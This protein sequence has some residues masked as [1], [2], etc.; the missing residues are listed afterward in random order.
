M[1]QANFRSWFSKCFLPAVA[2]TLAKGPVIL[3]LDGHHSHLGIE[4]IQMAKQ[5]KV[6]P[7]CIPSHTSHILQPLDVGVY[8]PL[9]KSWKEITKAY[10][11]STRASVISKQV[12]PSLL[13]E[14]WTKSFKSC[15]LTSGFRVCGLYSY[16]LPSFRHTKLPSHYHLQIQR[17]IPSAHFQWL[18][19]PSAQNCG[20]I[21]C[22]IYTQRTQHQ[23]RRLGSVP[24]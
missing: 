19:H 3:F 18:K 24:G 1:E 20:T 8:G 17:I 12:F 11:S 21:L 16:T 13:A 9:K 4:F 14:L 10:R 7:F 15:H 23:Q 6:H 5:H 2:D 22:V